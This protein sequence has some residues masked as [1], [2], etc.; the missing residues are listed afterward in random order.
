MSYISYEDYQSYATGID[1]PSE[2][3]QPIA[4][5][6]SIL[7]DHLT[8]NRIDFTRMT[9]RDICAVKHAVAVQAAYVYRNGGLD[10]IL[11]D[12]SIKTEKIGNNSYELNNI[13]GLQLFSPIVKT[14]LR[15]TGLLRRGIRYVT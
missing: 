9:Y 13:N 6:V 8:L 7:I 3:F 1:I 4:E 5:Y 14:L 10:S 2:E 12:Y 11:D 15:P